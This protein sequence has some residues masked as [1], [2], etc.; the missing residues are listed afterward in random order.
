MNDEQINEH[1]ARLDGW[2]RAGE[3]LIR[4]YKFENFRQA[5]AFIN[6]VGET[7]E[8]LNHHPDIL[9]H[10]W[11]KVRLSVTTHSAGRLTMKDF[12]LAAQI[13]ELK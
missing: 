6:R 13:N 8:M 12:Q 9:L 1:L 4:D 2:Q 10:G 3:E 11:N 5:L 7:A